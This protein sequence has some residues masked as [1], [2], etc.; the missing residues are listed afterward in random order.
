[1]I[2]LMIMK[3]AAFTLGSI[4]LL[5]KKI[6]SYN[7]QF[8]CVWGGGGGGGRWINILVC[9]LFFCCDIVTGSKDT[10]S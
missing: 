1:M 9:F 6:K 8:L 3:Q 4:T 5:D 7:S 10:V 2:N